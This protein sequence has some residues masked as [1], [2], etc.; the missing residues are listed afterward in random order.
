MDA[1]ELRI[2]AFRILMLVF[3]ILFIIG[4]IKYFGAI[5]G[6]DDWYCY[7]SSISAGR[8]FFYSSICFLVSLGLVFKPFKNSKK[9]V[10]GVGLSFIFLFLMAACITNMYR[11]GLWGVYHNGNYIFYAAIAFLFFTISEYL[12]LD[13]LYKSKKPKKVSLLNVLLLL[14][15]IFTFLGMLIVLGAFLLPIWA[16]FQMFVLVRIAFFTI[17]EK[18]LNS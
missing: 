14:G 17:D 15:G 8:Y 3:S 11:V 18:I 2:W 10:A 5:F 7:H 4:S 12:V 1:S 16:F 9:F 6:F 13:A